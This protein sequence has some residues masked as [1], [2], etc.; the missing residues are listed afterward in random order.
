MKG[1]F[2]KR[3]MR[4]GQWMLIA[5]FVLITAINL[6]IAYKY[7]LVENGSKTF[8]LNK[9]N[10]ESFI[11]FSPNLKALISSV[12]EVKRS[13]RAEGGEFSCIVVFINKTNVSIFNG[14]ENKVYVKLKFL[15][16]NVTDSFSLSSFTSKSYPFSS[17]KMIINTTISCI[18]VNTKTI[19]WVSGI[20]V[21]TKNKNRDVVPLNAYPC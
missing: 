10:Y 9:E 19:P 2:G 4:K 21:F 16:K 14:F 6:A 15:D 12:A 11:S 1:F 7:T 18:V 5:T 17:K 8:N 20:L 3:E 13:Y